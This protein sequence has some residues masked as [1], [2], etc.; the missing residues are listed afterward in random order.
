MYLLYVI[1]EYTCALSSHPW[2]SMVCNGRPE[3]NSST[4]RG[5]PQLR[6]VRRSRQFPKGELRL[7]NSVSFS[8]QNVLEVMASRRFRQVAGRSAL[9]SPALLSVFG[10]SGGWRI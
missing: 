7:P 9:A 8:A 10:D 3:V 5:I 2:S 6:A 4:P 1:Y